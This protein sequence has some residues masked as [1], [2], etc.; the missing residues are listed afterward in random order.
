MVLTILELNLQ[1]N[2]SALIVC[3]TYVG[4][5]KLIPLRP[6]N[7]QCS[8]LSS[9]SALS[10]F[11]ILFV[12]VYIVILLPTLSARLFFFSYCSLSIA[13][14]APFVRIVLTLL[15]VKFQ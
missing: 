15:L 10:T 7:I 14:E 4:S 5:R 6:I 2:I 12:T 8:R 13:S 1:Y 11:S 3:V 9:S